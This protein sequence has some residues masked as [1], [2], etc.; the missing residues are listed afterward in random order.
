MFHFISTLSVLRGIKSNAVFISN[1]KRE[2]YTCCWNSVRADFVVAAMFFFS[3]IVQSHS[4]PHCHFFSVLLC[5][6]L[7]IKS[8]WMR[9]QCLWQFM[10]CDINMILIRWSVKQ[11]GV[12]ISA[13]IDFCAMCPETRPKLGV[14]NKHKY[15][16]E[17]DLDMKYK[18]NYYQSNGIWVWALQ[19][20]T[21]ICYF[22]TFLFNF[23]VD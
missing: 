8:R 4:T 9:T 2:V 15:C 18:M 20:F 3:L 12:I 17:H 1:C 23:D 7:I 10:K 6:L 16:C 21:A 14:M 13:L 19:L 5:S 11:T 22:K